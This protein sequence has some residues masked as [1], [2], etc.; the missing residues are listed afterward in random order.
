MMADPN[1][2]A[3]R[4]I[5]LVEDDYFM[6]LE[7]VQE[8]TA[9]GAEVIGPVPSLAK[10]FDRLEKVKGIEGAI[11]DVN[12]QGEMVYPLAEELRRR[13]VPFVFATGYDEGTIPER[14]SDVPKFIKPFD[15]GA[16][17]QVLLDARRPA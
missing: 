6:V 17:A 9:S 14:Y 5:L 10:G 15:V 8:L 7:M 12:L 16:I 2:F 3:G 11:L 13:G 4:R 1:L